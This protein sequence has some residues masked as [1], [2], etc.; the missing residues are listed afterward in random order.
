MTDNRRST[1]R[2]IL[3]IAAIVANSLLATLLLMSA[4]GGIINPLESPYGAIIAMTF[5]AVLI[6]SLI[7]TIVNLIW[8]RR[9]AVINGIAILLCAGPILTFCPLN[10]F[11]PSEKAIAKSGEPTIKVLTF[12]VFGFLDFSNN[13]SSYSDATIKYILSQDA[14][15]VL[16]QEAEGILTGGNR[17]LSNGQQSEIRRIYPYVE[18]DR[19]GM[20]I[21]SK[22]PFTQVDVE[23]ADPNQ[24]DLCRYDVNINGM[25][26]HLFSL[27]MQSIGLTA[28][29]KELY[30]HFTEGE[31]SANMDK[32]RVGIIPKLKAAFRSRARQARIVREA[33][34]ETDGNILLCGDFNDIP[35]SY[36]ART[37]AG[38][39]LTDAYRHAG[40]G[41]AITYHA[42]RLYF[43]ID[44]MFYRGD[45]EALRAWVGDCS[46]SDHYPLLAIFRLE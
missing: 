30:R 44:Q 17:V 43:R 42:D 16:C 14:D 7:L 8:M 10:L 1:L 20:A 24:L 12:N 28:A 40:L 31:S 21:L 35:G 6:L 13:E 3:R 38:D 34:D 37:I 41:P 25:E 29:D 46:S 36:A 9:M 11:R 4:Y 22:Y 18:A 5:P 45:I 19:R 32:L 23:N 33:L 15:I 26:L 2:P 39:D 27:H